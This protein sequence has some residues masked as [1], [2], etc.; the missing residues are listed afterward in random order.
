LEHR[1]QGADTSLTEKVFGSAGMDGDGRVE[2][3][4][5]HPDFTLTMNQLIQWNPFQELEQMHERLA[6][7]F[8][9]GQ[10][11]RRRNGRETQAWAPAVDITEDDKS[12]V[13]KAELPEVKKEDVHVSVDNGLLTLSGERSFEREEKGR[14]YH[15]VERAYGS[16][17]RTFTLPENVDPAKVNASYKDGLLTITLAK[18]REAKPKQIEV[19]IE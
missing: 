10:R 12:Y 11:E 19:K 6:S 14:K 1:L 16:F 5:R 9:D 13:I 7:L 17:A 15:R 2:K 8:D 4:I 18:S 3:E